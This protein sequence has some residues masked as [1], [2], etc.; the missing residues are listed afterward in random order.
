[1][2]NA[3]RHRTKMNRQTKHKTE[4]Q[5]FVK[6]KEVQANAQNQSFCTTFNFTPTH[7]SPPTTQ[8]S[9]L[10]LTS[11]ETFGNRQKYIL[12]VND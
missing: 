9:L 11:T 12:L 8:I 10:F 6:L 1:M 4:S 5:R 7:P 2:P 3:K